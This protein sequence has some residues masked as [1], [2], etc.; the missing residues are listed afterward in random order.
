MAAEP[1][2]VVKAVGNAV[3]IEFPADPDRNHAWGEPS[4]EFARI[5]AGHVESAIREAE[6]A[7]AERMRAECRYA[8]CQWCRLVID[9]RDGEHHLGS[10]T[11]PCRAMPIREMEVTP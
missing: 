4:P 7:A 11:F 2:V 1:I 9:Y 8:M 5:V 10:K 3:F 6:R